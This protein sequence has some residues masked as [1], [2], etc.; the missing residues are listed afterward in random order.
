[1]VKYFTS[2]DEIVDSISNK[3]FILCDENTYIVCAKDLEY[4]LIKRGKRP[5]LLVLDGN[6]H[7]DEKA[8]SKVLIAFDFNDSLITVGSGTITDI[9][10]LLSCKFKI[11]LVAVATA[12]SMDG[13]ASIVTA[14]TIDNYK[15]TLSA[16]APD[17]IYANLEILKNSPKEL[18]KA[19][20]GDMMGKITALLDWKLSNILND[21]PVNEDVYNRMKQ[22][23]I[24]IIEKYEKEDTTEDLFNGLI[25]SGE[26]MTIIGNSR[27]ASGSEHHIAHLLEINGYGNIF[28]GIRVGVAVHYVMKLY[29]IFSSFNKDNILGCLNSTVNIDEWEKGV[30]KYYSNFEEVLKMNK[31]RVLSYNNRN[32]REAFIKKLVDKKDEIDKLISEWNII[33]EK[34]LRIFKLFDIPHS[35]SSIYIEK[36]LFI[37]TILYANNLRE[38]FT[39]LHLLH[40]LGCLNKDMISKIV[41]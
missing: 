34:A 1:M 36:E 41:C 27:P 16:K 31:N 24:N 9:G 17:V 2:M 10:K 12:P 15:L 4:E 7:A 21:E 23:I 28:H 40:F 19:G 26:L 13:Y 22:C 37:D 33:Y 20:F 35:Y 3:P 6:I 38:R 5:K 39:I 25:I 8:I 14:L 18:K 29:H 30:K 32:F 11:P